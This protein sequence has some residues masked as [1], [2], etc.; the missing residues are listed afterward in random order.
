M[1]NDI[2]EQYLALRK[3]V[4]EYSEK[5]MNLLLENDEQVYI[6]VADI[7]TKSGL[8]QNSAYTIAM[9]YGLSLHILFQN[10]RFISG[11]GEQKEVNGAN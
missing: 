2:S 5:D 8:Y 4:L 9:A 10:G 6:A 3:R 1:R 11:L 7:P